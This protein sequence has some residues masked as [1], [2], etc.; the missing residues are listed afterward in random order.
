[1][2]KALSNEIHTKKLKPALQM[3]L[4]RLALKQEGSC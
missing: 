4:S 1:M 3:N 2:R